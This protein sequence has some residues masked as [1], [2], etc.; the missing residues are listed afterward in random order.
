MRLKSSKFNIDAL[1]MGVSFLCALHCISIPILLTFS[2]IGGLV[3]LESHFVEWIF[4]AASLVIAG[5]SLL[6]SYRNEHRNPLP[7]IIVI[8]GFVLIAIAQQLPS[9][10][11]HFLTGIGGLIVASAH[12][13][14]WKLLSRSRQT[15][16]LI[17][18][19]KKAA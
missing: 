15:A 4:I 19:V 5:W 2:T 13:I 14:N 1:G 11:E 12:Y 10:S 7:L 17:A 16:R 8:T 6:H 18:G 3:W 9:N